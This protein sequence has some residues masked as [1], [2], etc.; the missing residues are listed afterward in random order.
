MNRPI[1]ALLLLISIPCLAQS[2]P[3]TP[4]SRKSEF[5]H[6]LEEFRASAKKLEKAISKTAKENSEQA[7][8]KLSETAS[9]VLSELSQAMNG[10]TEKLQNEKSKPQQAPKKK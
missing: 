3:A 9:G 2:T 10:L 5:D 6:A 8:Q 1:A 7:R 4:T